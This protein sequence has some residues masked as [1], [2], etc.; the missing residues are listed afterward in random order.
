LGERRLHGAC[1]K[2]DQQA[3]FSWGLRLGPGR[4]VVAT[5][6]GFVEG[7]RPLP[8]FDGLA[9]CIEELF[10]SGRPLY[11]VERTLLTSGALSCL[12]ESRFNKRRIMTPEL[13]IACQ[14]PRDA[15]FQTS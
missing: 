15:Y 1:K 9:H 14:A 6:F 2:N 3:Q 8:H 5:H 12:F 10:V 13:K 4:I 7:G 11:P